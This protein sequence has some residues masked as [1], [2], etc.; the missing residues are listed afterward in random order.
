MMNKRSKVIC[1]VCAENNQTSIV[2][3]YSSSSTLMY[4]QPYYDEQ[5]NYHNHDSNKTT[6]HYKCSNGH[7]FTIKGH[8]GCKVK[9]CTFKENF[10]III[11]E[12]K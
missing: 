4:C 5:G 3:N 8:Y 12:N 9:G 10:K 6:T 11:N 2:K 7:S 1:P